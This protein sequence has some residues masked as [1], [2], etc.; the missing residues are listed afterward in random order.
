[1]ALQLWQEDSVLSHYSY[2]AFRH[3]LGSVATPNEREEAL[4]TVFL[5][6]HRIEDGWGHAGLPTIG[7]GQ[8]DV[9]KSPCTKMPCPRCQQGFGG[10]VLNWVSPRWTAVEFIADPALSALENKQ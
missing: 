5:T 7:F 10:Y 3:W 4:A 8:F 9:R 2:S 1:M 6:T